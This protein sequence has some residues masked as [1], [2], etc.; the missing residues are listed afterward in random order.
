MDT[1]INVRR[2][3]LVKITRAAR[4]R[5]ISRSDMIILLFKKVMED[6]SDPDSA[7]VMIRYQE[8]RR[9]ENWHR[10]HLWLREDEYE[11][12]LDLRKLLKMSA[13]LILASAVKKYLKKKIKNLTDN[14]R[15][16]NYVVIRE[17]IDGLNCWKFIWGFPPSLAN[18]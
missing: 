6:M 15:I 8:R 3:V 13:S 12:V 11:Y 9:P 10:F 14:Y 4:S 18:V 7:G 2:D 5:G 16:R 17:F 1:T